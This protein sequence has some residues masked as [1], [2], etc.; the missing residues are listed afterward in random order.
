MVNKCRELHKE[1]IELYNY[2]QGGTI[3]NLRVENGLEKSQIDQLMM[4]L[5]EKENIYEDL[6]YEIHEMTETVSVLTKK[7]KVTYLY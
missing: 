7:L 2:T 3:E 6:Y 1:N 4:K 5:K